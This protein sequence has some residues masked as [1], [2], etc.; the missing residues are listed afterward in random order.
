MSKTQKIYII[1][2]VVLVII[3]LI[4]KMN[5]NVEKRIRFFKAD[6]IDVTVVEISNIKDTLRIEK[7]DETWKLVQPVVANVND[8]QLNS[9]FSK[10]LEVETSNLPISENEEAFDKYKVNS[11]QGTLL[12]FIDD[13]N[14]VLDE[15]I[16]GKSSSSRTTPARK[17]DE[18]KIY[19]LKE[20]LR[21]IVSAD[22]EK[23]REK[24][25]LQI[26]EFNISKISVI[27]STNAFE[28]T[29]S[30]SVWFY[31]DGQSN[32]GV[33]PA[34]TTLKDLLSALT[35]LRVNGFIDNKFSEYELK[36]ANPELEI[37]IT[38][39]DG[40]NHY[41]RVSA[42]EKTKYV[43]QLDNSTNILYSVYQNWLDKF[44]KEAIDFK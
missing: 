36:L 2:L 12:R 14:E 10:V 21:Y 16:I 32:L 6:S 38:L 43:L 15:A 23:W 19:E 18:N 39:L 31:S 24:N 44:N 35:D 20:S 17:L 4:T 13:K 9:L 26:D 8:H 29:P 42:D 34:N 7:L 5:N 1:I 40:S 30:D 25:I 28:L 22:A 11:S 3:F 27:G 41:I 37:G 33:D